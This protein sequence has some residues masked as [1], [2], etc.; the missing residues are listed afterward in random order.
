MGAI[1]VAIYVAVVAIVGYAYFTYQDKKEP[2]R[3]G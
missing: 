1:A 2:K 3:H